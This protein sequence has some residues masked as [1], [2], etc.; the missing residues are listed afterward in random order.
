MSPKQF[1]R[2]MKNI[3][4]IGLITGLLITTLYFTAYSLRAG[5]HANRKYYFERC[6]FCSVRAFYLRRMLK[7]PAC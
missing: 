5:K 2:I 1:K 7:L 4:N 3:N 6:W